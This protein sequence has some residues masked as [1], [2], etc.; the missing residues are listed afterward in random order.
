VPR[1]QTEAASSLI[2]GS[3]GT[4]KQSGTPVTGIPDCFKL[5]RAATTERAGIRIRNR[6]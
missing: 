5:G 6:F 4:K 3:R 2:I 1:E